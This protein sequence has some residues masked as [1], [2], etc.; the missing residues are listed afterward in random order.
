MADRASGKAAIDA[1]DGAFVVFVVGRIEEPA[2]CGAIPVADIERGILAVLAGMLGP[3]AGIQ[4][5]GVVQV[6]LGVEHAVGVF[7]LR[8]APGL[9]VVVSRRWRPGY[10]VAGGVDHRTA[11]VD[12]L[13][14]VTQVG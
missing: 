9:R 1:G 8:P 13:F 3:D 12:T 10:L 4:H 14:L 5:P 7:Q 11:L 2:A 6:V